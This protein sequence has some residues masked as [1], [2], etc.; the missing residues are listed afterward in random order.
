[1]A[2]IQQKIKAALKLMKK[3]WFYFVCILLVVS[4]CRTGMKTGSDKKTVSGSN[5]SEKNR[6]SFQYL[7]YNA[8][9]EKILSN[10]DAAI[11]LFQ[12]AIGIDPKSDAAYYE[13]ARIF[14]KTSKSKEG[15][16]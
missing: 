14:E 7:F 8:N 1:L 12:Q 3:Q 6:I 9:K 4:A 15:L 13:L 11:T 5:L 10:Y 16:S 2:I